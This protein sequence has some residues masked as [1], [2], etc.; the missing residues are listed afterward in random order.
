MPPYTDFKSR[1]F[2]TKLAAILVSLI[3]IGY[4]VIAGKQ[5]LSP[6]LFSGLLSI[7][8]LPFAN[9][10]ERRGHLS[11]SSAAIIAVVLTIVVIGL[12]IYFVGEQLTRLGSDWPQFKEQLSSSI[13]KL[14]QW[15]YDTL[16][17]RRKDQLN[18]VKDA[19][20]KLMDSGTVVL[21]ATIISLS[22]M[23]L[24]LAFLFIYTFL[25]LVYRSLIMKF[26]IAVFLENN[27][28]VVK[29]IIAQVQ[30]IIRQ[31]I[32]GLLLEMAVVATA[33][34]LVFSLL[35]VKYA[36]LLGVVT[37]L[38]NLIPY[39]GIFTALALSS[40]ITFA[41]AAGGGQVISVAITLVVIHLIDSNVLLPL[42]VGS[43][44][45]INA[46]ITVI[47]VVLGEMIWGIPGMFLSIPV[48]AVL[49]IIFDRV[50]SL[51][52]WG[53]LLGDEHLKKKVKKAR[54]VVK[55]VEKAIE[56]TT[57]GGSPQT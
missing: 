20:G 57:D 1:P 45:K 34:A 39:V 9:W 21:G 13:D 3:A 23:L 43:K 35:G 44:V 27:T 2:Y 36:V 11:R 5:L 22:S 41:T 38:F 48:I 29:D 18:Y 42:I 6:L 51:K 17:V 24:F 47:G 31:Y 30:V 4:L 50:D 56:E 15:I 32:L 26:F 25:F 16:H 55:E 54:K 12:V 37:G 10:L 8:L 49:K 7:L 28:R 46:L 19:T 52:P 53:I 40:L 14:Q 33:V